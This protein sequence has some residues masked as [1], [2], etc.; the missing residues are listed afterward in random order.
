MAIDGRRLYEFE[1]SISWTI[2]RRLRNR[3][4]QCLLRSQRPSP[5][6]SRRSHCHSQLNESWRTMKMT[7]REDDRA[8][9]PVQARYGNYSP[10]ICILWKKR[11]MN[12]Y[13]MEKTAPK[14]MFYGNLLY[15]MEILCHFYGNLLYFMEILCHFMEICCTLWKFCVILWKFVV[16]YGNF[17]SQGSA[18]RGVFFRPFGV[19]RGR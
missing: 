6:N 8:D 10:C 17:V 14:I 11:H 18:K 5:R 12:T 9:A 16:T 3:Q 15:F 1:N 2:W 4:S 7:S 13:F 19:G